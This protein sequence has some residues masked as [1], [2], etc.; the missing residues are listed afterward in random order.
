[1]MIFGFFFTLFYSAFRLIG[2]LLAFVLKAI[3]SI[4]VFLTGAGKKQ[5]NR[6]I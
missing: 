1:M 4:L 3:G 6:R 5:E 2:Q